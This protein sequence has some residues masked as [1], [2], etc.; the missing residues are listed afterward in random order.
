MFVDASALTAMMSGESDAGELLARL[1]RAKVRI[2]TPLAIWETG[3]AVS[4]IVGLTVGE[5][6][7]E[8][9]GFLDLLGIDI[10]GVPPET[11]RTALDVFERYGKGN[12]PARL[13]F[14]DCFAY[15][16]AR[17]F[18]QPLLFK[19]TDFARTDIEAA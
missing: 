5:A 18:G 14:G 9:H 17:H 13:N 11:S 3:V 6:T 16:C 10:R 8:V 4:R 7:A 19:G 1:D 15:A 12:H 2:T